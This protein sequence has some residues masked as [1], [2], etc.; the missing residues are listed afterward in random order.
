MELFTAVVRTG[1]ILG[2]CGGALAN[3]FFARFRLSTRCAGVNVRL[4]APPPFFVPNLFSTQ[5]QKN[6]GP[7]FLCRRQKK[8]GSVFAVRVHIFFRS[9]FFFPRYFHRSGKQIGA[10]FAVVEFFF[11]SVL[12]SAKFC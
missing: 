9:P 6:V 12:P 7:L 2:A 4:A 11:G 5:A 1:V 10:R 3:T 8:N